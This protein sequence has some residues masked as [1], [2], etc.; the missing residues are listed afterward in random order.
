MYIVA[1]KRTAVGAFGGKLKKLSATDLGTISAKAVLTPELKV[2]S[3]IFGNVLQTSPDAVYLARHVALKSG[4]PMS[5][6]AYTINRLCGSGFQVVIN[7]CEEISASGSNLILV[8][9]TESMSQAPFV[10]RGIRWG[11]PLGANTPLEDSL[12]TTFYDSHCGLP[13]IETAEKLSQRFNI[14]RKESDGYSLLSQQ[15]WKK[16]NEDGTFDT[17]ICPIELQKETFLIDEHPKLSTLSQLAELKAVS[18]QGRITAGNASGICDGAAAMLIASQKAVDE[19]N[20]KPLSKIVGYSVCGVDPSEMGI[21]PAMAIRKLL[22]Q[23]GMNLTDIDILEV[24]EAFSS[25]V[26][27]V[28]KELDVDPSSINDC[29]GGI[30]IGHP[31]A[32]SGARILCSLSHRLQNT[33]KQYALGSACIGGGQGIAVLLE[34]CL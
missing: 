11:I 13:M 19:Q 28:C 25:Q 1:A 7:A 17:E 18:S 30:S 22:N 29:G 2:D 4:L 15:R 32:A 8:G 12:M 5:T 14:T 24:N 33:G 31:L 26:L 23:K 3:V 34:N 9:G 21:G 20:L 27:A 6:P 10:T 16:A